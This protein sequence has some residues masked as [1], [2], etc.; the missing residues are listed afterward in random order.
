LRLY[1]E[2]DEIGWRHARMHGVAVSSFAV[3]QTVGVAPEAD[4]Y[5]IATTVGIGQDLRYLARAIR[6]ILEVNERLPPGRRIRAIAVAVGWN[7]DSQGYDE[8]RM[9]AEEAR[10][11]GLLVVS[12]SIEEVH[13]F[14][15][16]GLGPQPLA[17]PDAFEPY[18]LGSWW[19]ERFYA[20]EQFSDRLLLPMDSRTT[21]SS[22]GSEDYV[23]FRQGGWSWA[24]PYIAGMYALAVQVDATITPDE[25]WSLALATGRTIEVQHEG[26]AVSLGPILDPKA[27]IQALQ[28]AK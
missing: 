12:S 17:D 19:A 21:A 28:E 22:T 14:K 16:H 6:R 15:F 8:I 1:E 24:I 18:D 10:A 3:G 26:Q 9:V 5:F 13:G 27:L 20:G 2:T 4:L 7:Q 23:F 25:F 11:A